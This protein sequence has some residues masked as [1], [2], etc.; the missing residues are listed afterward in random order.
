MEFAGQ[1]PAVVKMTA[2]ETAPRAC[3]MCKAH[4]AEREGRGNGSNFD[5]VFM[6]LHSL[7]WLLR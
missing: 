1:A 2:F 3:V 6:V 4:D 5:K 7:A